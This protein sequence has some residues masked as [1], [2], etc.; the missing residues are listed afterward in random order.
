MAL[1]FLAHDT[2]LSGTAATPPCPPPGPPPLLPVHLP[3]AVAALEEVQHED[4]ARAG[5]SATAEFSL[6]AG[7]LSNATGPLQHTLEPSLRKHG[8]PT[9]LNKGVVELLADHT[10][11]AAACAAAHLLPLCGRA[12]FFLLPCR[13]LISFR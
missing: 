7:P 9:R 3:Q 4:Y 2:P 10:V 11:R 12:F 8:L 13:V 1:L 5:S 6:S